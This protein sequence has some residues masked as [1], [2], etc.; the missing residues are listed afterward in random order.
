MKTQFGIRIFSFICA[1]ALLSSCG[2][3]RTGNP[4]VQVEIVGSQSSVMADFEVFAVESVRFCFKRIRFKLEEDDSDAEAASST[5]LEIGAVLW[6]SGTEALQSVTVPSGSYRRIELDLEDGC[7]NG[8]SLRVVN[9]SGTF[10][11]DDRI[12]I[13]FEGQF[14]VSAA[15]QTLGLVIDRLLTALDAVNDSEN[16][17]DAAESVSGEIQ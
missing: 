15:D 8:E 17:K 3:T 10:F 16:L 11:T 9:D 4:S 13:R 6:S 2:N 14:E 5:D 1:M 12:T 7:S